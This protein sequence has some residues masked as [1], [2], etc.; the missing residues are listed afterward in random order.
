MAS[1]IVQSAVPMMA[2]SVALLRVMARLSQQ[3]TFAIAHLCDD[4]R[5]PRLRVVAAIVLSA[6]AALAQTSPIE[7]RFAELRKSP[8]QLH[9]FLYRMPKGA[10]LHNHLS[11]AAYAENILAIA[12]RDGLCVDSKLLRIVARRPAQLA[13]R[14]AR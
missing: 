13:A 2:N 14:R 11:G 12:A 3:R 7:R 10:D 5:M 8:P 1:R 9:E 6:V 4:G